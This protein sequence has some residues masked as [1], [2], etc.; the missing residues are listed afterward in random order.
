[1]RTMVRWLAVFATLLVG[2]GTG[3]AAPPREL[4]AHVAAEVNRPEALPPGARYT[5]VQSWEVEK[6]PCN[7]NAGRAVKDSD[8]SGGAAWE[9]RPGRDV[10]GACIVFGPYYETP[11]G[12][13]AAFFRIRLLE[14]CEE[15]VGSLDACMDYGERVFGR[16]TLKPTDLT[17]GKYGLVPFFFRVP[18]GG[19]LECRVHWTGAAALRVDKVLL[20]KVAGLDAAPLGRAPAAVPTGQPSNLAPI[21][22]KRPFPDIF[23]KSALPAAELLVCDVRKERPDM[24]LLVYCL[25]GLINRRQPRVYCITADQDRVWLEH[26][27]KRGWIRTTR[28]TSPQELLKRFRGTFKGL[29]VADPLFPATRNAA[30]MLAA[31]NDVL[32]ASPRLARELGLPVVDDLRGRWRTNVEVYRWAFDHLWP[33]LNH[34]VIACLWPDHLALRDYLVR[35]RIFIFWLSGPLDG[36]E[37]YA[38]PQE[39]IEA[40]EQFLARMPVNIPVMGYPWA[41][42]DVGIGEGPGVSLFAEFGKYL[43]GSIDC[44]N[45]SVHS[46]VRMEAFRQQPAPPVPKFDPKKIYYSFII[47]DGDNLPV[48]MYNNFPTNAYWNSPVRGRLPLGWSVSP[49]A[50]V[51]IPGIMDWYY[52]SATAE[53][54]FLCAVSG[55]GYTYPDLYG[56][57]FRKPYRQRAFDGFLAQTAAGM[58]ACDLREA[59]IMNASTPEVFRRYAEKV[60]LLDAIFPDYGRKV[61]ADADATFPTGRNVPVFRAVTS[62][63]GLQRAKTLEEKARLIADEVRAMTP[64]QRPAF[65]HVFVLNWFANLPVLETAARMLG[66]E[67][68]CVRPDQLAALFR[69]ELQRRKVWLRAPQALAAI[70]GRALD[71]TVDVQ[72]VLERPLSCELRT[73]GLDDARLNPRRARLEP[74]R[75]VAV[76][77]GGRP[78]SEKLEF[79]VRGAFGTVRTVIPVRRIRKVELVGTLPD[80][81]RLVP[82]AWD[83]AEKREHTLGER[84]ALPGAFGGAA[85]VALP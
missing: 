64:K 52:R 72:N 42:K 8:A 17:V 41:G 84:K 21:R 63:A 40:A 24:R 57:R 38:S 25:Q 3:A 2:R 61:S 75:A 85:W 53:D 47:S 29:V 51:L 82:A 15:P 69:R 16:R 10:G 36:A 79:E 73:V 22:E 55:I 83:E 33:R 23:P 70:E 34:H 37:E 81:A 59:W 80:S 77:V 18:V 19:K 48:L 28:P 68:V 11:P 76:Q 56:K 50:R 31:V 66:S 78:I 46:G 45:L 30:T 26:L 13:Y 65:L 14:P 1:M 58:E 6:S 62:C 35:N 49:A 74:G 4:P 7:H 27:R 20:Y 44:A 67:Y 39:E 5:P 54:A 60:P 71:F 9:A 43:V 12:D 32:P